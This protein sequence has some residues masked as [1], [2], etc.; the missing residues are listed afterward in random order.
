MK[1]A[2]DSKTTSGNSSAIAA[3]IC[4]DAVESTGPAANA[5]SEPR[6]SATEHSYTKNRPTRDAGEIPGSLVVRAATSEIRDHTSTNEASAPGIN[7][8]RYRTTKPGPDRI[9]RHQ[10][11]SVH[12]VGAIKQPSFPACH[13]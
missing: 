9:M 3:C 1:S 7:F 8:H 5:S 10:L 6:H 11:Q 13:S 2:Y 4:I 12:R